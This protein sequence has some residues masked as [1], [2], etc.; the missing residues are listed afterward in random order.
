MPYRDV[1]AFVERLR[2]AQGI[3]ALALE[4]CILAAA[5]TG[6]VL[7]ARWNEFDLRDRRVDGSRITNEGWTRAP[8]STV[9]SDDRD[10]RH[11]A[12]VSIQ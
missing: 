5:R 12:S 3:S 11:G 4:F 8:S 6:E 10:P 7:G 2:P 1:P 9:R